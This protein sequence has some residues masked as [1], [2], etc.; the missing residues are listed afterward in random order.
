MTAS[1]GRIVIRHLRGSKINQIEQFDLEG[2]QEI[3]IGRDPT[4]RIAYDLQRDDEVSRRHAVVRIKHDREIYFRLA[5][6]NSSNGT[7]LNG[8]RIGGEVELL[9]EDIVELGSG[10]PKFVFD[11]QPRPANLPARTRQMGAIDP[12][13]AEAATRL[14]TPAAKAG[15]T[16][17]HAAADTRQ[18]TAATDTAALAK[19]A[20]GKAT[21]QRMLFD[22]RRKSSRVL[23]ASIAAV[24]VLAGLG[25]GALLWHSHS[26]N[27]Q[28]EQQLADAQRHADQVRSETDEQLKQ[29][30]AQ[31]MGIS[32]AQIKTLGDATVLI[33]VSWQLYDSQT[34]RPLYQKMVLNGH[35]L[36]PAYVRLS[37]NTVVRWLTLDQPKDGRYQVV[38]DVHS[39]SGFVRDSNGYILTNIHVA[40][41][42]A[43]RFQDYHAYDW[44]DGAVFN[45]DDR[46]SRHPKIADA[47]EDDWV[48]DGGGY[49]F[50]ANRPHAISNGYRDFFG[51]NNTMSV[52]FPGTRSDYNATLVKV[53]PD[54]DVAEIKI[55][56]DT[57]LSTIPLADNN[58]NVQAG[59][60]VI[61]L[62]Y[63]DTSNQSYAEA[64]SN[65]RG[66]T[67]FFIPEPTVTQGVVAKLPAP[68]DNKNQG[69]M[70]IKDKFGNMY[71][72][73][74]SSG[75][76]SSGGPVLDSQGKVIGLMSMGR[77][78][79]EHVAF[80]VPISAVRELL[81]AQR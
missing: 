4:S 67:S 62:G 80:A 32:P 28:L 66:I 24:V 44:S 40:A 49:V 63:P 51:R 70:K 14:L 30:L 65:A 57:P 20:V 8:E 59:E 43:W 72:L 33:H 11:V 77:S 68:P 45:L 54:A 7:F 47:L 37:D 1:T 60:K 23:I 38:G 53:S 75:A 17:E 61:L 15:A 39:G 12:A 56:A 25:G 18:R 13:A 35:S 34:N 3:T 48:P 29:Q 52:R 42:W 74:I 6:L 22:E 41:S 9:P 78:D 50:E 2:L 79:A 76:G 10:G 16:V 36:I 73:D 21:I 81:R 19:V 64:D 55:D 27:A 69:D 58:D 5:D 71:Q 31:S 46:P 26:V